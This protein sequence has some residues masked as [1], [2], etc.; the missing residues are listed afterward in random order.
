M[1]KTTMPIY[2]PSPDRIVRLPEVKHLLG[3][4]SS[5]SI[6]RWMQRGLFPRPQR[7]GMRAVGWKLSDV[8]HFVENG[9]K[10]AGGDD[11]D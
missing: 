3:D 9:F 8:M 11:H 7:I 5:A 6:Y 10:P 4:V 1:E 2:P